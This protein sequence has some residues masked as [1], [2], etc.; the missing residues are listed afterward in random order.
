MYK[1]KSMEE[2]LK[3]DKHLTLTK[4]SC[5]RNEIWNSFEVFLRKFRTVLSYRIVWDFSYLR[6]EHHNGNQHQTPNDS[7]LFSKRYVLM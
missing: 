2:S 1:E 3:H 6:I 7:F 4:M 5:F